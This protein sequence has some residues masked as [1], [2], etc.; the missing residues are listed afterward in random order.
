TCSAILSLHDALPIFPEDRGERVAVGCPGGP[1]RLLPPG[2]DLLDPSGLGE[3]GGELVVD[4]DD[5][6][7]GA[8]ALDVAHH[9]GVL[10]VGAAGRSEEHTSELQSRA[11]L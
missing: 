10:L 11:S 7:L 2:A 1:V 6:V 5:V 3:H 8:A 4:V 9:L